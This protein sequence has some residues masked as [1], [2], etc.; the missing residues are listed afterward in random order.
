[1]TPTKQPAPPDEAQGD[2]EWLRNYAE[3][4]SDGSVMGVR[5]AKRL[6]EIAERIAARLEKDNG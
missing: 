2:A 3:S 1:M 4:V 5:E 6:R